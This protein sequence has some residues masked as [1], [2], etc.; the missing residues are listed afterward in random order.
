METSSRK[1]DKRSNLPGFSFF[2]LFLFCFFVSFFVVLSRYR[3][4]SMRYRSYRPFRATDRWTSVLQIFNRSEETL[5]AREGSSKPGF[6]PILDFCIVSFGIYQANS[7]RS[8]RL[9]DN[10]FSPNAN[11]FTVETFLLWSIKIRNDYR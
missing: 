3:S 10:R 4:I 2:S 5:R 8:T 9:R 11:G 6:S 7:R 1:N